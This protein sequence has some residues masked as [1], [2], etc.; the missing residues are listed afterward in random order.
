MENIKGN[1][2]GYVAFLL[3]AH[4]PFVR[5]PAH[6]FCLED[7]WLFEAL[8]E[9]YLPL[10]LGWEQLAEAGI[11]FQLTISISPTLLTMLIDE[12][13]PDRYGRYL[14]LQKELACHEM[15][16]TAGDPQFM[17]ITAFYY[18]RISNVEYM[19][20]SRYKEDLI[21]P[22]KQLALQGHLELITTSATHGYLPLMLTNEA[23]RAQIR[24]GLQLFQEVMGYSP[25]GFWLP[26]CGYAPGI[27][28]LLQT[29]GIE[30]F[31]ISSNGFQNSLPQPDHSFYAPV[32]TGGVTVFGQ[33]DRAYRQVWDPTE[34]YPA[35]YD[36]REFYRDIGHELDDDYIAPYLVGGFRGDTGFKYYRITGTTDNKEFYQLER[37]RVK[38]KTHA[39]DFVNNRQHQLLCGAK[40]MKVKPIITAP[41]DAELF[42]H[43]WFEGP[44]WLTEV[45]RLSAQPDSPIQ[46]ISFSKY[47]EDYPPSQQVTFAHS[48]WGK[49]GFSSHWLNPQT[50]WIYP[51]YHRAEK[52]MGRMAETIVSPTPLQKQALNQAAR[53]LLLA[54]SSDWSF[55]LTSNTVTDYACKRLNSH[56]NNFFK[57]YRDLKNN[58][59]DQDEL[60][61]LEYLDRI[62]PHI[63]YRIYQSNSS[64]FTKVTQTIKPEK[65]LILMLS[66][67]FP[68]QYVGGLGIHVRDLAI[69]L[70]SLGYNIHVLTAAHNGASGFEMTQGVGVHYIPTSQPLNSDGDFLIWMLQM[71]MALADYG[72][73]LVMRLKNPVIFHAH[74]WLVAYTAH[75]LYNTFQF[76]LVTTIHATEYGR[77]NGIQTPVQQVIHQLEAELVKASQQV[78]CCSRYMHDEIRGL[79]AVTEVKL[80]IIPSGVTPISLPKTESSSHVILYVGRL[81]AEKGVQ[82]LLAAFARL[83][84]MFRDLKLCIAGTGPH[85]KELYQLA[86]HLKIADRIEFKGFV[87]E[88][89]RNQLFSECQVA[90]FPS[91]YE[92][93]GIAVLEAM[94]AGVPVIAAHTG[95]M[96]ETVRHEE[97]G[98]FFAP[99]DVADLANCLTRILQNPEWAKEMGRR[100]QK[101]VEQDYTWNIAAQQTI[102]VYEKALRTHKQS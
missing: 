83:C 31:I 16:R 5:N 88:K 30:Y 65:P 32:Q 51:L 43:W 11:A 54:Q 25:K 46:T 93:F 70:A 68:P 45:L 99:G 76:P 60:N 84:G 27:E 96:T 77:N 28:E 15:E 42:G 1:P 40:Q 102:R 49:G 62:F 53:E 61:R 7:K 86:I 63:D 34:G 19:Y 3:H 81:V 2:L 55:I 48:S 90:V 101:I 29:E 94:T 10:L 82:H 78:M 21:T 91:L 58:N 17:E 85:Q 22:L 23:R 69:E 98:L 92:P 35:D 79:F 13:L 36:Y 37:A 73:E 95:G 41:Y 71:N 6:R 44:D 97:T 18:N 56:L 14:T 100:A 50:D 66:W 57:L 8:T 12:E 26:E 47:L 9:S 87:S 33:D 72:R 52:L 64:G 24:T 74:D 59:T 80:H 67:E 4:L 20:K 89:T 39:R 38:V 75:E